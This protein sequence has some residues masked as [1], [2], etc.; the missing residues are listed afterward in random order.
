[1]PV[2]LAALQRVMISVT[3]SWRKVMETSPGKIMSAKLRRVGGE[4]KR[5]KNGRRRRAGLAE[6]GADSIV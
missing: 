1:M 4:R 3:E 6:R 5:I 2:S